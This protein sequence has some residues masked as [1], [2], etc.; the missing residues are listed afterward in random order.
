[1]EFITLTHFVA[2]SSLNFFNL[3]YFYLL[4]SG[5][6]RARTQ[7]S[8]FYTKQYLNATLE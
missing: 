2:H 7:L 8:I 1:M 5:F 3:Y 6:N 4:T